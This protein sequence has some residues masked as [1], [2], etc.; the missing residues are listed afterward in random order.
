[1]K[2]KTFA[3]GAIVVGTMAS[4]HAYVVDGGFES[5]VVTGG[6]YTDLLENYGPATPV[7]ASWF[8]ASSYVLGIDTAYTEGVQNSQNTL[9]FI[10]QEGTKAID[11]TGAGNQG[12]VALSQTLPLSAGQYLLS[13]F[14]GDINGG[15]PRYSRA[16]AVEV[17]F[18]GSSL[19]TFTNA[20]GGLTTNWLQ[21]EVPFTSNGVN[22]TL[23]FRT[24]GLT[25]DNYTG[26]DNVSV[27]AVVPEPGS[28]A[29]VLAALAAAGVA[30]RRRKPA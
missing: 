22:N 7:G 16:S 18:G 5:L 9:R 23:T 20:A 12:A 27:T 17:L 14:L 29:M 15:D 10:A 4:A 19:G 25:L 26:L 13:F 21:V 8:N 3:L 2:L 28:L 24:T 1:M 6:N 30:A 11:L